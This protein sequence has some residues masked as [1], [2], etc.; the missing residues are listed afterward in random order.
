MNREKEITPRHKLDGVSLYLYCNS[1]VLFALKAIPIGSLF[2]EKNT[3]KLLL[4]C[5]IAKS[6]GYII[7]R[8]GGGVARE[9]TPENINS[10]KYCFTF[11]LHLFRY[12]AGRLYNVDIFQGRA[13]L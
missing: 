2:R 12:N 5:Y 10:I 9:K 7:V 8:Q 1:L 11:I 3:S 4:L 6:F 13:R